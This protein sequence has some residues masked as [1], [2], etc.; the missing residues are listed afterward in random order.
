MKEIWKDIPNYEDLYEISNFGRVK[1]KDRTLLHAR[2]GTQ[3]RK[4]K[5]LSIAKSPNGYLRVT[6]CKSNKT[7]TF[8]IHRLVAITFIPTEPNPSSA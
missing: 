7:K 1:S 6:L 4:G 5:L 2:C 3:T 8:S